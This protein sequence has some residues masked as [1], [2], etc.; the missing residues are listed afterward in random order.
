[1]RR[2]SHSGL[3]VDLESA[4]LDVAKD[5]VQPAHRGDARLTEV[6]L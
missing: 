4:A 1:V 6:A 3:D 2:S 5:G